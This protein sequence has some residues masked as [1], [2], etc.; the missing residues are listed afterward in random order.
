M[1]EKAK[2][3]GS[4]APRTQDQQHMCFLKLH[5]ECGQTALVGGAL[6]L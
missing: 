4:M 5:A 2:K 3:A 6:D 1:H